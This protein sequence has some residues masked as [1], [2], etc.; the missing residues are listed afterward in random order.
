MDSAA[1]RG[2]GGSAPDHRDLS[3]RASSPGWHLGGG[4]QVTLTV[5]PTFGAPVASQQSRILHQILAQTVPATGIFQD[6]QRKVLNYPVILRMGSGQ[7]K[8]PEA[9]LFKMQADHKIDWTLGEV[10][11]VSSLA[12]AGGLES[13]PNPTDRAKP[14]SKDLVLADARGAPMAMLL[15]GANLTDAKV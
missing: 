13:Q 11:S 14:G 5:W 15:T 4:L 7:E 3:H 2:S 12:M 1:W 10:D 9:I 8:L 6:R